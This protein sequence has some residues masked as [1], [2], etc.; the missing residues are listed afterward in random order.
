MIGAGFVLMGLATE[1]WQIIV[2]SIVAG[3]GN[4]VFH[5]ADYSILS[6]RVEERY[7]GRA[8]SI[9]GFSGYAGWFVAPGIM[10][11]LD[12]W[13]GWRGAI[14][15]AGAAGLVIAAFVV[16]QGTSLT[17]GTEARPVPRDLVEP[18][19]QSARKLFR[20]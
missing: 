11:A 10:L 8:V 14:A 2:L 9:H 18:R 13:L 3:T 15:A 20:R 4:G 12:A 19:G 17:E 7:M 6:A 1:F 5:P 16:W